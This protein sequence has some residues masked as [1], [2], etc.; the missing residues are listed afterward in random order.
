MAEK[1]K[2]Y[3]TYTS[4]PERRFVSRARHTEKGLN[5]DDAFDDVNEKIN[6]AIA[7]VYHYKGS[8]ETVELLPTT[9]VEVGDV[10]NVIEDGNNYAWTGT[11]WDKLGGFTK[12]FTTSITQ[13]TDSQ[14]N[15]LKAGDIVVKKT[16]EQNHT[17]I[18]TYQE[19]LHGI[20][21]SYFNAGYSETVSYD[22]I[23]GQWV[24]NSTDIN[25]FDVDINMNNN[26]I[27]DVAKIKFHDNSEQTTAGTK[28]VAN[29]T[30]AGTEGSLTGIEIA[31]VKYK[32]SES[33]KLYRHDIKLQFFSQ[34]TLVVYVFTT[35]INK[36]STAINN[37]NN[38]IT[39]IKNNSENI[40][41]T[42]FYKDIAN[43]KAYSI[44]AFDRYSSTMIRTYYINP[45]NASLTNFDCNNTYYS[46]I[47]D[48]VTEL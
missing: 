37:F 23:E 13:L 43:A 33:S 40:L 19:Y 25:K 2:Q 22:Y 41:C 42:G 6:D 15:E 10:Y 1:E 14:L 46:N 12:I 17:Y 3:S 45:D 5:I 29:P 7:G 26:D 38:F 36:S 44:I 11:E 16:G 18:V 20:C 24:Y 35:I 4:N 28:V 8:V 31:G 27:N 39:S 34:G 21:L 32:A 30:L 47:Y 9:D 48:N